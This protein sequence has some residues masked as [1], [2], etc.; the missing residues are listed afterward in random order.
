MMYKRLFY[1]LFLLI[2]ANHASAQWVQKSVGLAV[3]LGEYAGT[4]S[5]AS[6]NET[7]FV[8]HFNVIPQLL[9]STDLG[10]QWTRVQA[11]INPTSRVR[12]LAVDSSRLLAGMEPGFFVSTNGINWRRISDSG[13]VPD[14]NPASI[15][16][17]RNRY[18][19]VT[20]NTLFYVSTTGGLNWA[21]V[22]QP[23]L[24]ISVSAA[25]DSLFL[26]TGSDI[27][28]STNFGVS[29]TRL[30]TQL[31]VSSGLSGFQVH[32]GV[33]YLFSVNPSGNN[34]F[35]STNRGQTWIPKSDGLP[36]GFRVRGMTVAN[37]FVFITGT[38][39]AS[40]PFLGGV[41]R[42][43]V[44]EFLS[45]PQSQRHPRD[46]EFMLS[47]NYPNP[48]NPSTNIRYQVSG[49]SEVRLEVFDM[50]GRKVSTLVNERKAAGV[51]QVDFNAASLASGVYFYKLQ[52]GSFSET[53][54]MMLMK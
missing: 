49:V 7:L 51:Y 15:A 37:G 39:S 19:V 48:F 21:P 28:V 20:A 38:R 18:F 22:N 11:N 6:L 34:F 23:E 46:G 50:L 26:L 52:A 14:I 32:N 24:L 17:L 45:S 31:P 44:S 3:V 35:V 10:E 16:V 41:W 25:G 9:S 27:Y 54:K 4:L 5:I 47:Q 40:A 8:S 13:N 36:S 12:S 1:T 2:A 43:P 33:W 53:R 29:G 30:N 42:R